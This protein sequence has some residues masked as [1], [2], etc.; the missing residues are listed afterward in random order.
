MVNEADL[1][2]KIATTITSSLVEKDSKSDMSCEQLGKF[3]GGVCA[4]RVPVWHVN[5]I[6][7][8]G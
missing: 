5:R 1:A 4:I 6:W 7:M 2:P 3:C 8:A